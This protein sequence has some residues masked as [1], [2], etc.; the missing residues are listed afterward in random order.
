MDTLLGGGSR[1]SQEDGPPVLPPR[2]CFMACSVCV[3]A[4][5]SNKYSI[6]SS[7]HG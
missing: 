5:N 3:G 6:A 4:Y 2:V 1:S 7:G